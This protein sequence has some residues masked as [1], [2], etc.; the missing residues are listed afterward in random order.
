MCIYCMHMHM[1]TREP[2]MWFLRCCPHPFEIDS[3]WSEIHQVSQAGWPLSPQGLPACLPLSPVLGLQSYVT[4]LDL[5]WVLGPHACMA[6][7]LMTDPSPSP[8]IYSLWCSNCSRICPWDL[9]KLFVL[10]W[11]T[12]KWM[13]NKYTILQRGRG[14]LSLFP[15]G[16]PDHL[17]VI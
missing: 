14:L 13:M 2:L 8:S 5:I 1:E 7:T 15:H 12:D 6:S 17:L 3:L 16:I 11:L 10:S 9:F 4:V